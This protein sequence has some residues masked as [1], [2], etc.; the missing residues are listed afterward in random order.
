LRGCRGLCGW[1]GLCSRSA[2]GNGKNDEQCQ[3][4]EQSQAHER[5]TFHFFFSS[6]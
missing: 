4:G 1:G 3:C 5:F 2:R 6:Y